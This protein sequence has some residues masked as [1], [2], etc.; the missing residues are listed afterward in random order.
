[1][2]KFLALAAL[3]AGAASLRAEEETALASIG[4]DAKIVA[5]VPKAWVKQQAKKM[6]R[7]AQWGLPK[8]AGDDRNPELYFSELTNGGGGA[9]PNITRWVGEYSGT[10]AEPKKEKF[11]ADGIK[12]T[13]VE[14]TGTF[15][16]S[17]GGG[18]P[19]AGGT[20]EARK[21]FTTYA[22]FLE[23][24]G[25][26]GVLTAKLYGPKASVAAQKEAFV[27]LLKGLKKSV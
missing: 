26:D 22:A 19:F 1:M 23:I 6:F 13:M 27:K 20:K 18:G 10:D 3:A 24:P 21:G 9:D 12:I 4:A 17:M 15:M 16:E 5:Q 2:R 8:A 7:V 25:T 14:I 11:E